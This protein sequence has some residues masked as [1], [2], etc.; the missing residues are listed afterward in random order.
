[1][2][3]TNTKMTQRQDI[4]AL[5]PWHAAGT[6][7]RRDAERVEAAIANDAELARQ[8]DM[9]REELGETIRLNETLGAPSSRAMERLMAGIEAEGQT[10][11]RTRS[12]F[13]LG[14]WIAGQLSLLSPR[15]LAWSATAAALA[16]V[17]QAGLIAGLYVEGADK[18]SKGFQTASYPQNEQVI[19]R[20]WGPQGSYAL[21]RFAPEAT[22]ADITKFLEANNK[23]EL[24]EGPRAGGMFKVKLSADKLSKEELSRAVRHLQDDTRIIR[25]AAP[26]E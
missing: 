5:L 15:T 18:S 9:V 12:S 2:T 25:F 13:N 24:V 14:A 26:T 4:E 19:T 3:T 7:N 17:L 6:L 21:V 16:I 20:G 11:R 10:A 1:M 23:A 22:A 8:Y